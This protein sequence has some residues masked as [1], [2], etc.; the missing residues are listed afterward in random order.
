[1][2]P[3]GKGGQLAQVGANRSD[4]ALLWL[5]K[6]SGPEGGMSGSVWEQAVAGLQVGNG[7]W[8]EM[9]PTLPGFQGKRNLDMF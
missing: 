9:G 5:Q 6:G 1:M 4:T 3:V 7:S 8:C 2:N